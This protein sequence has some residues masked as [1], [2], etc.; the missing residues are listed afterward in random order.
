MDMETHPRYC[1][2]ARNQEARRPSNLHGATYPSNRDRGTCPLWG[3]PTSPGSTPL[4]RND[5]D[6]PALG[7]IEDKCI[8]GQ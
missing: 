2:A 5:P 1:P 3:W 6:A 7:G 8:K 4:Q